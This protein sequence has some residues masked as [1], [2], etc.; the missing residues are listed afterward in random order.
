MEI[1]DSHGNT[2]HRE[3]TPASDV[4]RWTVKWVG[5]DEILLDSSDIGPYRIKR[6]PTAHG[7]GSNEQREC[8]RDCTEYWEGADKVEAEMTFPGEIKVTVAR[9]VRAEATAR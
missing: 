9:E 3:V 2:V 7:R 1:K 4:Q 6:K 5:N 8:G